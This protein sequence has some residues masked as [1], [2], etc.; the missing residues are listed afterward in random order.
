MKLGKNLIFA[1]LLIVVGILFI[2]MKSGAVSFAVTI[3]GVALIVHGLL[4]IL[5]NRGKW[6]EGAVEIVAG[7]LLIVFAWTIT[8][9]VLYIVA[10]VL[11]LYGAYGIFLALTGKKKSLVK[12][13]TALIVPAVCVIA[14]VFLFLN[15]FDWAFIIA[16]VLLAVYGVLEGV[17]ALT[18]K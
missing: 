16:G 2:V 10:A 18:D 6:I 7:V 15:G 13:L 1:A 17:K 5:A 12:L 14:G 9:V 3:L 4:S 8:T 11:V